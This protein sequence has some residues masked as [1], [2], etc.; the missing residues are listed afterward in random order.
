MKFEEFINVFNQISK[1][2]YNKLNNIDDKFSRNK[3]NI[4]TDGEFNF[5]KS[6]YVVNSKS[7]ILDRYIIKVNDLLSISIFICDNLQ[8]DDLIVYKRESLFS[9]QPEEIIIACPEIVSDISKE[10]LYLVCYNLME[11][12]GFYLISYYNK[13]ISV[14]D[15]FED[16]RDAFPHIFAYCMVDFD[17]STGFKEGY[18]IISENIL[19]YSVQ[20]YDYIK[21]TTNNELLNYLESIVW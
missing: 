8:Y 13:N 1:I 14:E 9:D 11:E 16:L 10:D 3:V 15:K 6:K 19:K 5:L 21:L 17:K 20:N 4:F 18:K 12:I 2:I 7:D